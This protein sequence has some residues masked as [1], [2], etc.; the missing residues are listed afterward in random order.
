MARLARGRERITLKPEH[1]GEIE[2][3]WT[4]YSHAGH[5]TLP[6]SL[7]HPSSAVCALAPK[8]SKSGATIN[9]GT[10]SHMLVDVQVSRYRCGSSLVAEC[11]LRWAVCQ[12][13]SAIA[14]VQPSSGERDTIEAMGGMHKCQALL[15]I[16][17]AAEG[18]P[19]TR[20]ELTGRERKAV[21]MVSDSTGVPWR[22]LGAVSSF[23][24]SCS[25]WMYNI[26]DE[27]KVG[28]VERCSRA[29]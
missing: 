22:C 24:R 20:C 4:Q 11:P 17:L 3:R 5:A 10:D 29:R 12:M 1:G 25:K 13:V 14:V 16:V 23:W 19:M 6:D 7:R 8:A 27:K 18:G 21:R 9:V 26:G 28:Q 15:A 2:A